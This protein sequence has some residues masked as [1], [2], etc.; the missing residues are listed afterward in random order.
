MLEKIIAALKVSVKNTTNV[1]DRTFQD[2]AKIIATGITEEGQIA[3]AI[4]P[5]VPAIESIQGNINSV[6]A[7]AVKEAKKAN[8]TPQPDP[9][10]DETQPDLSALIEA[11]LGKV[12]DP[13]KVK[14]D[15]IEK[16]KKQTSILSSAKAKVYKEFPGLNKGLCETVFSKLQV[17]ESDTIEVVAKN[18]L[19]E[20]NVYA[21][22]AG[23]GEAKAGVPGAT[24]GGSPDVSPWAALKAE[25][26]AK[27]NLPKES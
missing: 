20:Y 27:G 18:A 17:G 8:Q 16:E 23:I 5:Y 19:E 6:V 22:A 3:E 9:K 15:G 7:E 24:G 21:V 1:S 4:K 26:Q 25:E 2:F 14:L 11:A 12:I 13:I 10:K